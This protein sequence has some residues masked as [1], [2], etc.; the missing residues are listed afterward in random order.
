MHEQGQK[1]MSMQKPAFFA[2]ENYYAA[3]VYPGGYWLL[4]RI[5]ERGQGR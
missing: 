4:I 5:N 2:A 1:M 3:C